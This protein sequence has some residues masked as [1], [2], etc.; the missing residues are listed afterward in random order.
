MEMRDA[1]EKGRLRMDPVEYNSHLI[2]QAAMPHLSAPHNFVPRHVFRE[3]SSSFKDL[4]LSGVTARAAL[5]CPSPGTERLC[6]MIE[7]VL[8][9]RMDTAGGESM[10][11]P[12]PRPFCKPLNS[13]PCEAMP[14]P[15]P[16]PSLSRSHLL[17]HSSSKCN[18]EG[19]SV[20][21]GD[22]NGTKNPCLKSRQDGYAEWQWSTLLLRCMTLPAG[23][24]ELIVEMLPS[25]R[26]WQW[27]LWRLKQRCRLAP[28]QAAHDISI[29]MDEILTDANIF[30][31]KEQSLHLMRLNCN[32][33]TFSHL[34]RYW[35]MSPVLLKTVRE[36]ADVQS[37]LRRTTE[38]DV[39]LKASL[40]RKMLTAALSLYRWYRHL[41]SSQRALS[42]VYGL[43]FSPASVTALI[44]AAS[45]FTKSF[46][47]PGVSDGSKKFHGREEGDN[48]DATDAGG[49]EDVSDGD[50][51]EGDEPE[52][53]VD[54]DTETEMLVE[55]E[56]DEV[57]DDE[58]DNSE[59]DLSHSHLISVGM[60]M[61]FNGF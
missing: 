20:H 48:V 42:G 36:W 55:G 47:I 27:S 15:A 35:S 3:A 12:A 7:Q 8:I 58:D 11:L 52:G 23:I 50:D 19:F 14:P 49:E 25:P 22:S 43:T 34:T 39:I 31:G 16:T 9:G 13:L 38:A 26:V 28:H 1:F 29:L 18:E 21:I 61:E 2:L 24:F 44:R 60:S 37:L 5:L 40:V 32:T 54:P 30:P 53:V 57:Q 17:V 6:G 45:E 59:E 56:A 46:A 10:L 4:L 33:Q 41:S 51:Q